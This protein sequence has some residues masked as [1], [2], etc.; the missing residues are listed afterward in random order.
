M[1]VPHASHMG[2]V[3]ERQIQ[4][5]RNILT[6]LLNHHG[7]QLDGESV[8]SFFAKA[9]T[10][11]NCRPLKVDDLNNAESPIPLAPCR[12][13]TTKSSVVLPP[14]GVFQRADLYSIKRWRRAQYL[15]NEC[16]S[17]WKTD[18]LQLLQMRKKMD[19][20]KK[21]YGSRRRGHCERRQPATKSFSPCSCS[22]NVPTQVMM[23][24]LGR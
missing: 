19:Q 2:D 3:W 17:K 21:K 23:V 11:V 8:Y 1:N 18:Y 10:I 20:G 6:A 16:W 15:V 13:V 12:L 9:E 5:A 7:S 14:P 4:T 22:L 24:W